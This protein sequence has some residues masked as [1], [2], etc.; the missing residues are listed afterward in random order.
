M[1]P[2]RILI[3]DDHEVVRHGLRQLLEAQ[4]GWEI[5]GEASN[6]REAI[7]KATQLKPNIVVMDFSMPGLNGL[8]ATLQ[9]L[10]AVPGTEVLVLTIHESEE[11][12][13]K[14][15][16]AG[17]RGYM[18]KSDAGRELVLA[19]GSLLEHRVFLTSRVSDMVLKGYVEGAGA[20]TSPELAGN[21]LTVREREVLQ[22]LAEGKSNKE[23]ASVLYISVNTVE[24]HRASIMKK[25]DLHSVTDL[26]R[27]AIRNKMVEP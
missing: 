21:A 8:E 17:A 5:V 2:A 1:T 9:I 12:A 3:A 10:K 7:A 13:R 25:L 6:G 11:V 15:L 16:A 23:A 27:Y 14:V 20:Q 24:V 22:L 26:V 18:L 19:V 4:P